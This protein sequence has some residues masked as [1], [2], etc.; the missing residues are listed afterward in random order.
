MIG[1]SAHGVYVPR[2]RLNKK[3]IAMANS[4]FD[5][6][7]NSLAKGE[8]AICNWDEDTKQW[9][10]KQQKIVWPLLKLQKSDPYT[11]LRRLSRSQIDKIP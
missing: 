5:A 6:S 8:R 10:W 2:A 4:W 11:L 1:V 9:Q 3:S 7:L